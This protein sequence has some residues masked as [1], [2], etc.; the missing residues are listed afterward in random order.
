MN[1]RR[2]LHGVGLVVLLALVVPFVIYAV[3]GVVG[4]EQSYVILSGSM[5]PAL[6][7]GDAIVVDDTAPSAIEEG[8]VVTFRRDGQETGSR[9]GS[10]T[11]E[12]RTAS[13]RS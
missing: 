10:S 2:L 1:R 7:P 5:E 4:A 13:G 8:D 3:P 6:S 12:R 11:F 9:T